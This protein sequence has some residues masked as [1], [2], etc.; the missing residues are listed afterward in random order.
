[1]SRRACR[2]KR[3]ISSSS[4]VMPSSRVCQSRRD[5]AQRP[6]QLVQ[7]V[8]RKIRRERLAVDDRADERGLLLEHALHEVVYRVGGNHVGDVDRARLA[9]AIGAVLG[10][11]VVRGHPVEI[12]EDHLRR[13]GQVGADAAGDDVRQKDAD[14]LV[15]LKAIDDGLAL[16]RPASSRSGRPPTLRRPRRASASAPRSTRR[17]SPSRPARPRRS[18]NRSSRRPWPSASFCRALVTALSRRPRRR[19]SLMVEP[20]REVPLANQQLH[21][22]PH[23]AHAG[24]LW[25]LDRQPGPKLGRQRQHLILRA[26]Q[27]HAV[28]LHGQLFDVRRAARLPAV[29]VPFGGAVALRERRGSC[30]RASGRRVGAAR[31][32]RAAGSSAACRSGDT[33]PDRPPAPAGRDLASLLRTVAAS[34]RASRL[35][36]LVWFFR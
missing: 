27:H 12:V 15:V 26:P 16:D 2:S 23:V 18:R 20:G 3:S 22:L 28:Q 24:A 17:R 9:D 33:R 5:R 19:R 7:H 35:R 34:C 10:L 31:R 25:H 1:M 21:H 14:A 8:A 36:A 4:L 11:P 30:V 29:V 32:G 13:G 6:L